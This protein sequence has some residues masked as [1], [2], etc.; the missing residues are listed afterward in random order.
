ERRHS[1]LFCRQSAR[2]VLDMLLDECQQAGVEIHT[3]CD[4]TE[5][6][7]LE[8]HNLRYRL[9][10]RKGQQPLQL[11]CQ[12]LVVATGALSIPT[13]GGSGMGYDIATQFGLPLVPRRAGLVPFMFSD[14]MKAVCER[15]SGLALEV[16]ASC[17]DQSFTENMLF[18]HRGISG[19]AILQISSYWH[20]GDSLTLDLLPGIDAAQWLREAKQLQARQLLRTVLAEKL[21]RALVTEL[22]QLWWPE[23]ADKPL[24]EF[25]DRQL[26]HIAGQLN[27]WVIKPSAT[28]GYR[29]AEVTL[30]GVDTAA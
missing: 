18:T 14:N 21:G 15:L 8:S 12:S 13:L 24:A 25:S 2:E 16:T 29:T 28:E 26:L 17:N 1:Q 6:Q 27:G 3:H 10:G 30:G 20:P 5:V 7:P 9:I 19:P 4:I 11:E 23:A 22:Q